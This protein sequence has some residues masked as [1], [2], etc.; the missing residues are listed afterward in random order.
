MSRNSSA[1][2]LSLPGTQGWDFGDYPYALEPLTLPHPGEPWLSDGTAGPQ[3]EAA[4]RELLTA[5][6]SGALVTPPATAAELER[7]FWFRWI[8]GHHL[9]FVIWRLVATRLEQLASGHGD[10]ATA[11]REI[12]AYV[13]AYSA[14][15]LYTG[16]STREIYN[17]TIRPSMY[18][19][20]STFSGTWAA[21][22][23]AVRGLFRGRRLPPVPVAEAADLEREIA[24][25]HRI[26]L[27]VAAKLVADGR[28]LLQHLVDKP[29]ER[30]PRVWT[31]TF[32]CYFLTLRAPATGHEV[33]A[34]L[35]RR[36][37]AVAMDLAA[38][39]LYPR[40]ADYSGPTPDELCTPE[41]LTCESEVADTVLRVAALATGCP[42]RH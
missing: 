30:Q 16:S 7:L 14:M 6:D 3:L 29:P 24:L 18:R 35:L 11:A 2:A 4:C 10:R 26:H 15:M 12:T 13:R 27:G 33:L 1:T 25:G 5:T 20:H 42:P 37:K 22:Y 31:S 40:V 39:G 28:S 19:M 34:Q 23:A 8:V 36:C 17:G 41:T 38:N 21:D 9:S 32:D